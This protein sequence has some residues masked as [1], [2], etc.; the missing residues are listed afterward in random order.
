MNQ[1]SLLLIAIGLLAAWIIGCGT[2][3]TPTPAPTP[4]P[5]V[6]TVVI[7]AT[8][9]P[10]TA[11]PPLPTI[12]PI[13]TVPLTVTAPTTT[14]TVAV[15]PTNTPGA[16]RATPTRRPTGVTATVT[17]T[18]FPLKYGAPALLE[19]LW[20]DTQKDERKFPSQTLDLKWKSLGVA[21]GDECYLV[22]VT[23]EATNPGPGPKSDSFLHC[24]DLETRADYPVMFRL[25]RPRDAGPNYAAL[26]VDT[27]EMW[28]NWS[29][30]VVRNLG[31]CVDKYH[32]KTAPLGPAG[33][34]RFLLKGS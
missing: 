31:Q 18:P 25:N 5:V 23:F 10:P 13:P 1:K 19:P 15:R 27:A 24:D 34:G 11:T 22:Q 9:L 30:M 6:V 17:A 33:K 26:L 7:T 21:G 32:C 12:T 2:A 29:V 20:T 8:P 28:V 3:A 14:T 16:P 4:S